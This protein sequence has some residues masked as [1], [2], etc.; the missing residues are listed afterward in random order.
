MRT[1][2]T[3]DTP[4]RVA[5]R[6]RRFSHFTDPVQGRVEEQRFLETPEGRLLVTVVRPVEPR[7]RV[8]FLMCHSFAWEQFE[9]FALELRFARAAAAAGFTAVCFQ[10]RGYGD[11]DGSFAQVTPTGQVMDAVEVGRAFL[12]EEG[13]D[14]VVPV[15]A[16]FGAYVALSAAH[17]LASPGAALW[18][19]SLHPIRYLDGLLKAF[20]RTTVMSTPS[21]DRSR[22]DTD[23]LRERLLAGGEVDLFGYPLNARCYLDAQRL[24]DAV[25]L[26]DP[27]PLRVHLVVINPRIRREAEKTRAALEDR[28]VELTLTEAD[29]PGHR[30]FGLGVPVGGHLATHARLFDDVGGSTLEWVRGAS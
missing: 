7:S 25:D 2:S 1:V 5:E 10:A 27:F 14:H 20:V 12:E 4:A 22:I 3:T 9:L 11:S 30:E 16:R 23:G 17:E 29:A 13:I 6:L 19:P 26:P 28:G 21:V 24:P 18:N 15:G 8:A